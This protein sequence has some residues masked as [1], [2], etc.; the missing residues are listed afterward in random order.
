[1]HLKYLQIF[2]SIFSNDVY[3]KQ[4]A[5][6]RARDAVVKELMGVSVLTR[7]NNRVYRVDDIEWD[8]TPMMEFTLKKDPQKKVTLVDYYKSH[9]NL[10]IRDKQ[11]PL[12]LHRAKGKTSSGE[13]SHE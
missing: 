10:E 6:G 4:G 7:Y 8:K 9:W 13:V 11:Q 12:I 3:Q 2:F 1:M 5:S